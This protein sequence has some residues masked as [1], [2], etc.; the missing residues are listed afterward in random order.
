MIFKKL[1]I[2]I[3]FVTLLN[4]CAQNAVL[5]GPAY[6]LA[7][8]GNVYQAGITYGTNEAVQIATG[9]STTQNLKQILSSKEKDTKIEQL[10]K[11]TLKKPE[12]N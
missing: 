7:S 11:K 10:V 4:G 9:K 5:L 6:T 8:T 3:F 12:K 1:I 2:G